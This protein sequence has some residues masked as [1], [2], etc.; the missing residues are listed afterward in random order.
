MRGIF[1]CSSIGDEPDVDWKGGR[2]A[3]MRSG[4]SPAFYPEAGEGHRELEIT[5]A[6]GGITTND[7]KTEK[8][9]CSAAR[10]GNTGRLSL[11]L[12][13]HERATQA[14]GDDRRVRVYKAQLVAAAVRAR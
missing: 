10:C 9:M 11:R 7:D 2:D 14:H 1:H 3:S 4:T 6:R 5:R 12:A 13:H 8:T